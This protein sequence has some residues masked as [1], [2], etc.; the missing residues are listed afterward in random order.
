MGFNRYVDKCL[1]RN[2]I[3]CYSYEYQAELGRLKIDYRTC[4]RTTTSHD[5]RKEFPDVMS[6]KD[7]IDRILF[8]VSVY[9]RI[10]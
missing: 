8:S 4:E 1:L 10:D 5:K 9:V 3:E 7:S 6:F 2:S